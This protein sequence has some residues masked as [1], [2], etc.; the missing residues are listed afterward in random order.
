M[1]TLLDQ[2]LAWVSSNQLE[3]EPLCQVQKAWDRQGACACKRCPAPGAQGVGVKG[4]AHESCCERAVQVPLDIA[5]R[6][7]S[8]SGVPVVIGE[9]NHPCSKVGS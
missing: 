4:Q 9:P 8:D 5:V 2:L 6:V 7:R 1:H 3:P